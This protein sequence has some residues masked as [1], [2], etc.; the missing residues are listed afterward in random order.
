MFGRL[1]A[2]WNKLIRLSDVRAVGYT[3]GGQYFVLHISKKRKHVKNDKMKSLLFKADSQEMAQVWVAK[4]EECI[5]ELA[6]SVLHCV[7]MYR[8]VHM[9]VHTGVCTWVYIQMCARGCTYRCVHVG[10]HTGVCTWVCMYRCVHMGVYVQVCAHGCTYRCVHMGVRTGVC[11]WV[12]MYRCVHMGVRTGVH[13]WVY[14]Q[15]CAHGW[16]IRISIYQ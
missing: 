14:I 2:K 5:S 13:T 8:C 16:C 7:C 3:S 6:I 9:G 1:S 12:C 11:T 10:V 15:V 4:I